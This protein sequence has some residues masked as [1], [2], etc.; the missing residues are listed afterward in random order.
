VANRVVVVGSSNVDLTAH[1]DRF[2]ADGE[3]RIGN[4]F[5]QDFG[6][7]GANQAVMA[8]RLGGPVA[9][10]GRVGDD[11]LGASIVANLGGHGIDV[12]GVIVTPGSSS[13]VA[14]I[15]V[16]ERGVN[17]IIVVPGANGLLTAADVEAALAGRSAAVVVAQLETPQ[18]ATVA[19]FAWARATGATTILN[20]APAAPIDPSLLTL[21]DWLI[22]NESEFAALAEADPSPAAAVTAQH[23]WG[24]GL[25]VT[26]GGRG[27]L[28]V[29]DDG[30]TTIPAP[31]M[32]AVDTTGAG[33]AFVGGFAHALATVA[34]ARDSARVGCACGSLSVTRPGAQASFP[35]AVEVAAALARTSG[36][37]RAV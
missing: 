2:P 9:F 33:D 21:T 31:V 35:T 19:A 14:P 10:V 8:A 15:W 5:H 16:D 1:C 25:V 7:K 26:L 22:P 32:T 37:E 20:P 18:A 27:V 30:F 6:G 17:R 36:A 3:T 11:A 24:C 23:R 13:G 28:V 29:D 4:S 12:D 34:D